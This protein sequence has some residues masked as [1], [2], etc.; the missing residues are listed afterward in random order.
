MNCSFKLDHYKECLEAAKA[1]GYVFMTMEAYAAAESKPEKVVVM[2]H[3]IDHNLALA[4]P[5]AM[6]EHALGVTSTYFIRLHGKYNLLNY[7]NYKILMELMKLGHEVSLHHDC[8]FAN[9]FGKDPEEMFLADKKIFELII[10]KEIS[11]ISAH[12][13]NKSEFIV[14]DALLPKLGLK[15]QAYADMFFKDMK[16][17]S[18]SSSRWREGCM[19]NFFSGE[20]KK[21]C[22][23]THPFWWFDRSPLENY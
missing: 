13:P 4:I 21:L 1:N 14:T 7:D 3:D 16:Y 11:G 20:H 15:Y 22:I 12:E 18:D 19:C 6:I 9:L 8:D 2:R 17:I 23:L 10:G 5:F